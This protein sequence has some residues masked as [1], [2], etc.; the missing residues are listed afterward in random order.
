MAFN[1]VV[2]NRDQLMLMP[3]SVRDWLPED[4]LAWFIIDV[5]DKIDT[6]AF[7]AL[8]PNDGVGRPAY[9]PDMMLGLLF[10]SYCKG[11]RRSRVIERL[12]H[13]DAAYRVLSSNL[14]PDHA[15][16]SRFFVDHEKAIQDSFISIL[17]LCVAAGLASVG[18]I[19]IDGTKIAANAALDV[20]TSAEAIRTQVDALMAKVKETAAEEA[21]QPELFESDS[22]PK[23]LASHAGRLARLERAME[24]IAREESRRE[25][26][27]EAAAEKAR[28]AAEEGKKVGGPKPAEPNQALVRAEIEYD[29]GMDKLR[30]RQLCWAELQAEKAA[31]GKSMT[32]KPPQPDRHLRK[33]VER[34]E[35]ARKNAEEA[36]QVKSVKANTTDPDSRIM[37]T[38]TGFIQGY[39]AQ[40]AV[41]ENQVVIAGAITQ[42]GNDSL[43]YQPMVSAVIAAAAAAGATD[44]IGL[45]LADAGYWSEANATAAGPIRLIATLKDHK[46]RTAARLLGGTQGEPAPGATAM[47][48]MEHRLRTPEGTQAYAKR[49][50]TVEPV[51]GNLKEN[52]GFTRFRRRGLDAVKSEWA[53]MTI[54]QNLGKLFDHSRGVNPAVT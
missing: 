53:L 36:P 22:L 54:A 38:K 51:F 4:D 21:E 29:L 6:S 16:L 2:N 18:T 40:A 46:Q 5:V 50:H 25:R 48:A 12:C 52:K 28:D 7:H 3:V 39:N 43:Q 31:R 20:N 15:T 11:E 13:T 10:Y 24:E 30:Q 49:S 26:E 34:L 47:E 32:G 41:N 42:E 19:A 33:A 1:Y 35:Q 23:E 27:V 17:K 8:H 9:D 45:V 14:T 44:G 37:K